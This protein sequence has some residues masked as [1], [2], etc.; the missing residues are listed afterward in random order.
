M[1]LNEFFAN[2]YAPAAAVS[3]TSPDQYPLRRE[4][5]EAFTATATLDQA[6]DLVRLFYKKP[7]L[8]ETTRQALNTALQNDPSYDSRK[9]EFDLQILAAISLNLLLS[10]KSDRTADCAALAVKA[11]NFIKLNQNHPAESVSEDLFKNVDLYLKNQSQLNRRAT[12]LPSVPTIGKNIAIKTEEFASALASNQLKPS[13]DHV[14]AVLETFLQQAKQNSQ[15]TEK[16]LAT[17]RTAVSCQE[18]LSEI[19]WWMTG[20][21][22]RD[23]EISYRRLDLNEACLLVGKELADLTRFLPSVYSA[24]A[25]LHRILA[26][27]GVSQSGETQEHQNP[28]PEII[29]PAKIKDVLNS[30]PTGWDLAWLEEPKTRVL[31]DLCPLHFALLQKSA[32]HK[33]WIKPF[34]QT[35]SLKVSQTVPLLEMSYQFYLERMLIAGIAQS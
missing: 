5:V 31:S 16:A 34:E 25:I 26:L 6:L 1:E 2:W 33:A 29:A 9:N 22:S 11:S 35:M 32:Y 19:L 12:T 21:Y 20:E 3:N 17:L 4:A 14:T 15:G 7:L 10:S 30:I 24:K 13:L 23:L 28:K 18:E 8:E 27:A